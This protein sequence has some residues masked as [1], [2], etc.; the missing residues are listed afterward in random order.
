M[1]SEMKAKSCHFISEP[2]AFILDSG[3]PSKDSVV[4]RTVQPMAVSQPINIEL[5]PMGESQRQLK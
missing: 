2:V 5:Q 4:F 3:K 1:V